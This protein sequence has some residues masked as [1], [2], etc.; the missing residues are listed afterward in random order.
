MQRLA[1]NVAKVK[2]EEAIMTKLDVVTLATV[3]HTIRLADF[4][5]AVGPN[6]FIA[7]QDLLELAKKKFLSQCPTDRLPP[8]QVLFNDQPT[9]DFNTLFTSLPSQRDYFA[10][11]IPGSFHC[12]VLPEKYV[13]VAHSSYALHWLSKTPQGLTDEDGP[14]YNKGHIHYAG[15]P[16]PVRIAYANRF[17]TDLEHFLDARAKELVPG[18]MLVVISPSIPDDMPYSQVANGM[19]YVQMHS[20]LEEMVM[21]GLVSQEEVDLFNLPIY[22]CP[23]G[24]FSAVVQRNGCFS[25]EVIGLTDPAPWLK[26]AINMPVFVKHV[27][28]AMEG[29]FNSHFPHEITDQMFTRLVPKLEEIGDQMQKCYRDGLQLFAVLQRTYNQ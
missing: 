28:A 24:E 5:C 8:F 19:M 22:A 6:T 25:I 16:E 21:E 9:N 29:M 2:I 1:A 23:P 7:M 12:R 17:A 3:S 13:H 18:G 10:A 14:A 26:G 11:G 27:R 4:G 20:I 15:A